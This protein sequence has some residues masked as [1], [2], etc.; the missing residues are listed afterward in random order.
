MSGRVIDVSAL[1][2]TIGI[3]RDPNIPLEYHYLYLHQRQEASEIVRHGRVLSVSYDSILTEMPGS[4]VSRVIYGL[5]WVTTRGTVRMDLPLGETPSDV[6][7]SDVDPTAVPPVPALRQRL[8][9][10]LDDLPS[11]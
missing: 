11:P 7:S 5:T 3:D 1:A 6:S 4:P 9:R 10:S 2:S 8:I